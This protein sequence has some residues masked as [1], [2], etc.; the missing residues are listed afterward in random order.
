MKQSDF[1]QSYYKPYYGKE[2][3]INSSA[4]G[5]EQRQQ[6]RFVGRLCRLGGKDERTL[7]YKLRA[8]IADQ[9]GKRTVL[10]DG[11][12]V[13]KEGMEFEKYS[14]KNVTSKEYLA[15][16]LTNYCDVFGYIDKNY[17]EY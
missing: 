16:H 6:E 5:W 13:L 17:G 1:N 11:K 7:D 15:E 12:R 3:I 8:F 9:R 10:K 2:L 4:I 14:I